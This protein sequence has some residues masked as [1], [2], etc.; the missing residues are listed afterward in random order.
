MT[1]RFAK[2]FLLAGA[3][4]IIPALTFA[5]NKDRIGQNGA[6][7]LTLNPWTRSTG[8]GTANSTSVI[9]LE[10]LASNISGLAFTKGTEVLY[11]YTSFM[12]GASQ[13]NSFG[14]SQ[15]LGEANV[16]A[17]SI[18]NMSFGEIDVTTVDN[19]EGGIGKYSPQFLNLN[20]AYARTFS[21]SI[22]AGFAMK[23]VSES[24][25]NVK[26][27]G[28]AFD[29]GIRYLTGKDDNLKFG[30]SLR[31]IGPK[32]KYS[33]DGLAT[34]TEFDEKEFTL[35]Q[36]TEAFELPAELQIGVTYDVYLG[37]PRD[38]SGKSGITDHRLTP[39][40]TFVSKSF[41]KDQ[42]RLGVEYA[43]K[44]MLMARA[45]YVYEDGLFDDAQR[46]TIFTGPT[47][48]LTFEYPFGPDKDKRIAV[49]YAYVLT[50]PFNG[51][52]SIGLRLDL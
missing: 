44:E 33:G 27:Q 45:G 40:G 43:W 9:G 39:A 42:I 1:N 37:S 6:H 30:I 15:S 8:F 19:P 26:T 11:S 20:I 17:F 21:N 3:L 10:S 28:V 51:N 23:V 36:R 18:M 47:F 16:I 41:G 22:Y 38:T 29:L 12:G 31:N 49:D 32:M 5:G 2:I 34:K 14:L 50:N 52:H 7:E 48:G 24:I 4:G 46:E 25:T 35:S 13:V